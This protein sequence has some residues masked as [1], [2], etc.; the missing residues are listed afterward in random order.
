MKEVVEGGAQLSYDLAVPEYTSFTCNGMLV[1]NC[2][3]WC[4]FCHLSWANKP[5]R[6]ESVGRSVA[7]AAEWRLNQ[8]SLEMSPF[9]PDF[10]LHSQKKE[11]SARL[12]EEVSDEVD[13]GAMR[14]DD[15][16]ADPGYSMLLA[17]GGTDA[18]TLGLEGNS[19]RMRDLCGKGVSDD[20]VAEAVTQA[21]RS[22]IRKIKLFMISN[23]PGE[24]YDDVIR[25]VE[26][27]RRLAD[28]RESFGEAA[29]G[30]II[31]FSWTP[32]LIEAQTPMQWF[33]PTAPDYHLQEAMVRL[34]DEYRVSVK[35]GSKAQPAKQ[36]FFQACQRASRDAG[37]AIADV[38]A[39]LDQASWGGMAKDMEERLSAALIAHGF[40]N[41]LEDLFGERYQD[42]MLGWEH[43]D[44]G[45]SRDL[46]WRAYRQMVEFLEGTNAAT[47]DEQFDGSYRGAEWVARCDEQCSGASCGCCDR[48]DLELRRDYIQAQDR[49]MEA[50]PL[51]SLDMTTVAF[52]VRAKAV[53]P[54]EYKYASTD[55][56]KFVIRRAAYR[57]HEDYRG[58]PHISKRSVRLAS[59]IFRYR[60]RSAG[61]DYA[62]FG[63]TRFVTGRDLTLF[64]HAMNEHLVP[65]GGG[66]PWLELG[67]W[68]LYPPEGK[69][70]HRPASLWELEVDGGEEELRAAVR[71][72]DAAE[73]VPVLLRTESFYSG[74]A[75]EE[76]DAKDHVGD[77]WLVRDKSRLMLRMTLTGQLGPYQ[78]HAALTGKT[79]L[80]AAVH[81]AVRVDFFEPGGS[82]SG[83]LLT[84]SCLECG[85]VIPVDLLGK[86]FDENYCPRCR[87][88]V[89]G[90][91]AGGLT[92][93]GV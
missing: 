49:D 37:E 39:G 41:G 92:R 73:T 89:S 14:I 50:R 36:A 67:D 79:G 13:T 62:E 25:I 20:D 16:N 82:V 1:H 84:P 21:I 3:A 59:E 87:D 58:V 10:P 33:A 35:L 56:Y 7:R 75:Q 42:D 34:R 57:A 23:W 68:G 12:M 81:T 43:I 5:Y 76:A 52:L 78:A 63:F 53:R 70:P 88:E 47:Y 22:G 80:A 30:I 9:S 54:E 83:S 40:R 66:T 60:D 93:Q 28:I 55:F 4:S 19:Q 90:V 65:D 48:K 17:V 24:E 6:Q 29:R 77:L 69:L 18:V 45:V 74:V 8:G 27:G 32:L 86:P 26:L 2:T 85:R 61:A 64:M 31:Q 38:I 72:W 91:T 71:R 51:Q 44:T 46:M 11:L 15:F